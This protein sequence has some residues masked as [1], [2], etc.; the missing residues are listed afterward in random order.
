MKKNEAN[1]LLIM[2]ILLTLGIVLSGLGIILQSSSKIYTLSVGLL[3]I[4]CVIFGVFYK[5]ITH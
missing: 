1:F 3:I 4:I 5:A 2:G